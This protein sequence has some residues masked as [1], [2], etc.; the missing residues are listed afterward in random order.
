MTE[1]RT[2]L[3]E[4]QK[5]LNDITQEKGVSNWLKA[6]PISDQGCDLN[7]QQFWDSV[8]LRYGWRLT[9]ISSTFSCRSKIVIQHAMICEKGRFITIRHN[10][11]RDLTTSLVTEECKDDDIEPQLLPVT[12]ETFNNRT[13]NTS[14]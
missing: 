13:A 3:N 10:D 7:K 8:R 9:N 1:L 2:Q 12:S 5:R 6:Y 11:L 14:H 4:N